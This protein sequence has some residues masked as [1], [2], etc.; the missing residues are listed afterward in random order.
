[1]ENVIR[2]A[3]IHPNL[4]FREG[5]AI[6]LSQQ[7]DMTVVSCLDEGDNV[8]AEVEKLC[9]D[10]AILDFSQQGGEGLR[11]ALQLRKASLGTKLVLMGLTASEGDVLAGVEA[12]ATGL[13]QR[14]ASLEELLQA[15]RTVVAGEVR[16]SQRIAAL[17][18]SHF[19]EGT[20]ARTRLQ[21]PS[22]PRLTSRERQIL[23]L[24]EEGFSNKEIAV[25]LQIEVQTV[26]NH[27]HNILEKLQ[28]RSRREAALYARQQG[29]LRRVY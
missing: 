7:P 22:L 18:Y 3:L 6:A 25:R 29:L 9:P 21:R 2:V 14:E 4:L 8:L 17:L 5:L 26:K 10:V 15:I 16:F 1:M 12:G 19:V 11:Q 13:L 24:I 27:V 20:H 28:M 23:A